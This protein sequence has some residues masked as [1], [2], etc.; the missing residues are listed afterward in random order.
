[1][2]AIQG[3][4]YVITSLTNC[5]SGQKN[6]VINKKMHGGGFYY[7]IS[8]HNTMYRPAESADWCQC[9]QQGVSLTD[10]QGSSDFLGDH[11]SSQIVHSSDNASCFHNISFSFSYLQAFV[12]APLC[13][14]GWQKSLISDWGIVFVD[15]LQSLRHGFAVPPPFAQGRLFAYN[16]FT[17]YDAIICK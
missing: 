15:M 6:I 5:L 16:N 8:F 2:H 9:C 3:M 10:F 11:D 12:K 1:M 7:H 13:K 17:N 4:N 14:G